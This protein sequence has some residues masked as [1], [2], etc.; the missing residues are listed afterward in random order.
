MGFDNFMQVF[1]VPKGYPLAGTNARFYLKLA[2]RNVIAELP[3]KLQQF[4]LTK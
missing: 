1:K 2:V 3:G 4:F